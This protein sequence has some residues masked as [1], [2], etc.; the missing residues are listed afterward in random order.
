MVVFPDCHS[1]VFGRLKSLIVWAPPTKTLVGILVGKSNKMHMSFILSIKKRLHPRSLAAISP[2]K[3][4][5]GLED[6]SFPFGFWPIFG[7][8]LLNFQ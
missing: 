5:I 2:L 6:D 7:G 4:M 1:L 8:E 3:A